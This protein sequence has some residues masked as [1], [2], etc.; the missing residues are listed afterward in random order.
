MS[1]NFEI[2]INGK[3]LII[4]KIEN[5]FYFAKPYYEEIDLQDIMNNK[6]LKQKLNCKKVKC[7]Y[8]T[9]ENNNR[10]LGYYIKII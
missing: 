6:E 4:E 8:S 1:E 7:E 10:Y 9:Q 5:Q 3:I 2:E